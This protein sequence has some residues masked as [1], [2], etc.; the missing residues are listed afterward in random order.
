MTLFILVRHGETDWNIDGRWQGQID[1][2]L[3]E[4][5]IEQASQI[6]RSLKNNKVDLIF[7]SDLSR[8]RQTAEAI[9]NVTGAEVYLDTRLREI[10]QG[11]WQGMLVSDIQQRYQIEF[12]SRKNDPYTVAPPG[13]E[14]ARQ[15]Q[16]R[17]VAFLDEISK[18]YPQK[19]IAIVSH[20]FAI[21]VMIAHFKGIPIEKVWDLVP[22]NTETITLEIS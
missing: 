17:V 18:R 4:K 10:H 20:G 8:A 9:S 1:V 19:T 3:N 21:A 2:P 12:I 15:V 6:A 11:E 7:S 16:E 13:G 5:G 22:K 14:T